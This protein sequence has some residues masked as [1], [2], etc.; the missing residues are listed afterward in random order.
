MTE[1]LFQQAKANLKKYWGYDDF[2]PGQ[3]EVV[4]SVLSGKSTLVLFP[5]G[6]GKSLC[7]QV[8]ATVLDGVTLVISPLVALMQDQVFQL[9]Q[10]GVP[11]TFIN[12]TISRAEVEQRLIN[13]R[14]GMYKLLYCAPERLETTI[15]QNMMGELSLS[16]IAIDEAHCISE[17]GHD[18]RPI[19]RKIPEMMG[20]VADRIGWLALTATAT[21]EVR[22]DIVTALDM[23]EP[24]II[25]RGFNRPNLQWWVI[26]EEQKRRRLLEILGRASGSGLI[27][28]GTRAACEQ[29]SEWLSR[30]GWKCEPYHAGLESGQRADIQNR[31]IDGRLPL[32]AA[33]N[34]FGMGIDKPDCRFV[35]HYDMSKSME[36][37][38]QEAGRAGRDGA[39]SY[40]ILLVSRADLP[41]AKQAILDSW[42]TRVQLALAYNAICDHWDLAAGSHMDE[43]KK[44]DMEQ[45]R[46]RSKLSG[47]LCWSAVR[48]LDQLGILELKK[49][50]EPQVGLR[51]LLSG[52]G[53]QDRLERMDKPRKRE[54]TD[55]L[56]RMLGP[57]MQHRMV[58]IDERQLRNRLQISGK[59]LE[60]GLKVL[61]DEGILQYSLVRNE[62]MGRLLEARYQKFSLSE[63]EILRHRDRLLKKLDYMIGY[64]QTKG[65]RS[66]Y[67]RVYF[68]EQNVPEHCGKC[69]N[70][71]KSSSGGITPEDV[72]KV[73]DLLRE[74]S[75]GFETLRKRTR[76]GRS[77]LKSVLSSMLREEMIRT[78]RDDGE[79]YL[80]S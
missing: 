48:V 15:W 24:N 63:D 29:L 67:I 42:P 69:D 17:W 9:H 20:P 68:G 64:V 6:G 34:A 2:R 30:K 23:K 65:C 49:N 75:M 71:R 56:Y 46:K 18:F 51:F 10:K 53:L 32:V 16:L 12:S 80:I 27:Y 76:W 43:P 39:E 13:A 8:P 26:E 55:R 72:Q 28:A 58:Y 47:R 79:R 70:C 44:V 21:P 38:Y 25:S 36:A 61:A 11:A 4:R 3:D 1:T 14:N 22:S 19:Y 50:D 54:F 66:R 5:T 60:N 73:A 37:Y 78:V 35:V 77:H 74:E 59:M 62:P 33:T 57:E 40:P 31:W 41:A 7:Y 52:D 45:I